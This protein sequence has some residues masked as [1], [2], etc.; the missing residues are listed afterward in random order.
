MKS[1]GSSG[2]YRGLAF[3]DS[4]EYAGVRLLIPAEDVLFQEL[5][6]GP[7]VNFKVEGGGSLEL[8]A[9]QGTSKIIHFT[10]LCR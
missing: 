9:Y 7:V 1:E 10:N 6:K 2:I 5:A 3:N 8:A 4:S